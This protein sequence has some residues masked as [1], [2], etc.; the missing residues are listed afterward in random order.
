MPRLVVT[1]RTGKQYRIDGD[2]N[3][4]VM[5]VMRSEGVDGLA[6]LCGGVCSCATCHIHIDPAF[7]ELLPPMGE[8]ENLLL[9]GSSHRNEQ[10]RLSCQIRF[11]DKL[12]GLKLTLAEED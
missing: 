4:T 12:S 5:E 2:A 9:E 10:S 7:A 1:D 6:A 11:T 8:D 3:L